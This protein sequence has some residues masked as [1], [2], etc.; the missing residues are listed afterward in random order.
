M[1]VYFKTDR[2]F[3]SDRT[4]L[5]GCLVEHGSEAEK[6]SMHGL[7]DYEFLVVKLASDGTFGWMRKIGGPDY[8]EA[9]GAVELGDIIT[10][11][12]GKPI[13]TVDELSPV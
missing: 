4:G 5:M 13:R 1:A 6:F 11:I 10:G 7:V 8:E 12:N 3:D 9:N 2:F